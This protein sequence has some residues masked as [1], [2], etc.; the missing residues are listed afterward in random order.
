MTWLSE[1][2]LQELA[3]YLKKSG[4]RYRPLEDELLDHLA[5]LVEERIA[6]GL[7]YEEA[8]KQALD[9]FTKDEVQKT[10]GRTL[11]FVHTKPV[12]MKCLLFLSLSTLL[13]LT[14]WLSFTTPRSLSETTPPP[15]SIRQAADPPDSAPLNG[16]YDVSAP[17]G[18]RMHPVLQEKMLH[19]GVDFK[20]P[21]G[22]PILATADGI[23]ETAQ[24]E[25]AYGLKVVLRHD[26]QYQ[27]L[28]AHLSEIKVK[29]GESVTKGTVIGLVGSSG[30]SSGPHL[31]YEILKN[32]RPVNPAGYMPK[33]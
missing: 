8:K 14:S 33:S 3:T 16:Q 25:K 11:Y 23:V 15:A 2:Q 27:S 10:E 21:L 12:L 5:C 24:E 19:R 22:T 18:P 30:V 1:T 17:Y 13:G 7:D 28:Y 9:H 4:G 26:G 32:G 31:H 29:A 20:A 6:A